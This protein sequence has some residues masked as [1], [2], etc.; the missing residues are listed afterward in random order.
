M[1]YIRM[2]AIL[3]VNL[4]ISRIALKALGIEDF[5]IYNIIA[6]A[7]I[8]FAFINNAMVSSTQRFLNYELGQGNQREAKLIFS[9]SLNIHFIIGIITVILAETI[10]LWLF[11]RYINIP[12][13]KLSAALWVYHFTIATTFF[14]IIRM[15]YIAA[16]I[17]HERMNSYAWISIIEVFL[18]LIATYALLCVGSRLIMYSVFL[19]VVSI[20]V[21]VIYFIYCFHKFPI[22]RY[23]K[24]YDKARYKRLG[25]FFFWSLS[26]SAANVGAQQGLN[27][28][29]NLF[30]NVTVNA[31]MGIAQQV[32]SAVYQIVGNFQTAF[33][34]QIVKSYASNDRQYFI[35]LIL[36]TS[37]YSFYLIFIIA[38]PVIICCK[39]LLTVWLSDVPPY[40]T[41]LSQLM[42]IFMIIDAL[43]GPLWMSVQATGKIRN[44]QIL[45]SICILSNLPLTCVILAFCPIP[46]L[47]LVIRIVINI[48][49]SIVRILYIKRLYQFPIRRYIKEVVLNIVIVSVP[50]ILISLIIFY[51]LDNDSF[52]NTFCIMLLSFMASCGIIYFMGLKSNEKQLVSSQITRYMHR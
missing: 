18:K 23:V 1:L 49:T 16:I 29:L 38:L 42:I 25:G 36:N 5:G 22:C 17:A 34:P 52:V 10:G 35:D 45:M 26:G 11:S 30:F 20:I 13:G 41:E 12:P 3:V 7:I 21:A 14:N 32:G 4:Y 47:A 39:N 27:I 15:P 50:T 33:N 40:A 2:I 9:S 8:L 24:T 48:I 51:L 6:C 44:Y 43:Q 19:M 37:R 46:E 28:I 31:A